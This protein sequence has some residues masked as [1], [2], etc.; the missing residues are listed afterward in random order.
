M[1]TLGLNGLLVYVFIYR[2]A[3]EQA[4]VR[5]FGGEFGVVLSGLWREIRSLH[6]RITLGFV[7]Q[8]LIDLHRNGRIR[9]QKWDGDKDAPWRPDWWDF[10]NGPFRLYAGRE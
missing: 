9:L 1:D 7:E 10:F 8:A 6:P 4:K 2:L 5:R 3:H